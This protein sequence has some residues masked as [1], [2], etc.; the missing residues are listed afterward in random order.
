M[1]DFEGKLTLHVDT[2]EIEVNGKFK[3]SENELDVVA[4]GAGKED[5][6]VIDYGMIRQ[7]LEIIFTPPSNGSDDTGSAQ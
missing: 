2:S 1:A 5:I 3:L 6:K 7:L 4:G